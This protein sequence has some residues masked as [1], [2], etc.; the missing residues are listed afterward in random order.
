MAE[1]LVRQGVV[2]GIAHFRTAYDLAQ[3]SVPLTL[4]SL[5]ITG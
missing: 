2:S 1:K 3:V 4:T 5:A